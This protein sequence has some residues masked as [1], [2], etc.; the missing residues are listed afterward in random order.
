MR[1]S[2]TRRI[3]LVAVAA[4]FAVP[5]TASAGSIQTA[6]DSVKAHTDRADTALD[7][8][9]ALYE[10][11]SDRRAN[12]QLARSRTEMGLATAEAAKLRRA[13]DS[14]S[15]RAVAAAAHALV[16]GQQDENLEQLVDVLDEVDGRAE[17]SVAK[18]ALADT[19]GRE[20][21][22]AVI[23]ALVGAGVSEQ[24]A[25]GLAKALA[26]LSTDRNQEITDK[27][28]ALGSSRVSSSAKRSVAKSVEASV[29]G[30]KK[31]AERL[32][33]LIADEE[34]PE[35]AKPGLQRA[36]DAVV[37]EHGT[38][39]DILSRFSDQMP[40]SIRSYVEAIVT[41]ARQNAQ[42]MRENR[43]APPAGQP[44]GTPTGQPEGTPSG[45]PEGTPSGQSEDVPSGHPEGTPDGRPTGS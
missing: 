30:Q 38:V 6:I 32:A 18:A 33:A 41:Q 16:A 15:E 23:S 7:R 21:A 27:S 43:P 24:A 10:R 8:A 45:Q 2:T 29:R 22:I 9:V 17:D 12:A 13:A 11:N 44:D 14:P 31:A 40:A 34:V 36:Y 19:R 39:A 25:A 4:A 28:R 3:G 26:E 5:G 37:A 1:T 42:G 20:K 35:A